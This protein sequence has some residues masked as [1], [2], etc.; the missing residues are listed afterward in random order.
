MV[1]N[2][3]C[4]SCP[5]D[6]V[7]TS[8]ISLRSTRYWTKL[9]FHFSTL[10]WV[11][12]RIIHFWHFKHQ[13]DVLGTNN[14]Y[15]N[16][17]TW[18]DIFQKEEFV[19]IKCVSRLLHALQWTNY[20]AKSNVFPVLCVEHMEEM[21]IP[22]S[23]GQYVLIVYNN[24]TVASYKTTRFPAFLFLHFLS[25]VCYISISPCWKIF[26]QNLGRG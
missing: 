20:W 6:T 17:R 19:V 2:P 26:E 21:Y 11:Y 25:Y 10:C 14:S 3:T 8:Q 23:T 13:H 5:D 7:N 1:P 18:N 12:G 15:Q 4:I 9:N 24:Q 22:L 16:T